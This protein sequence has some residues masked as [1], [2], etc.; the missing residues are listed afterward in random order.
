MIEYKFFDFQLSSIGHFMSLKVNK[1]TI[2]IA[3]NYTK[4]SYV[5]IK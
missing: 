1:I 4:K 5:K 2:F 3:Y